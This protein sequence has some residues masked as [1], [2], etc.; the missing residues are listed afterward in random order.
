MATRRRVGMREL[1]W[2]QIG[3]DVNPREYG[4][5]LAKRDGDYVSIWEIDP[6]VPDTDEIFVQ[7]AEFHVSDLDYDQSVADSIGID[8]YE[9][10]E[11]PLEARAEA[12]LGYW[13]AYDLGGDQRYVKRWE[14]ALP[15]SESAIRWWER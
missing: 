10:E 3:G 15:D 6:D 5:I 14:D 1:K 4:A 8:E 12:F 9:W 11:M 7:D 13:G 2:K